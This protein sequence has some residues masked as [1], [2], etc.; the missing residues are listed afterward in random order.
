MIVELDTIKKTILIKESFTFSEL[1]KFISDYKFYDWETEIDEE[2]S[3][4]YP[5]PCT[6][7]PYIMPIIDVPW[8]I[9]SLSGLTGTL[10]TN[11][12]VGTSKAIAEEQ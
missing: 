4:S 9:S 7:T 11:G 8:K 1:D 3:L 5:Q 6:S 12:F 10:I 2:E